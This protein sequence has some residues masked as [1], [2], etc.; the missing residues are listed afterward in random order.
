LAPK[1]SRIKLLNV[2]NSGSGN[3]CGCGSI[4]QVVGSQEHIKHSQKTQIRNDIRT[5]KQRPKNQALVQY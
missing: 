3:E 2:L 4:A 1:L 5:L